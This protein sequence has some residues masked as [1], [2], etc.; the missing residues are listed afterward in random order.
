MLNKPGFAA[1]R[2]RAAL[3]VAMGVIV[4][5]SISS[6]TDAANMLHRRASK[7]NVKTVVLHTRSG[8]QSRSTTSRPVIPSQSKNNPQSSTI[9]TP[10]IDKEMH[11]SGD[12][13][14]SKYAAKC[15]NVPFPGS[16]IIAFN[17]HECWMGYGGSS[18]ST[19]LYLLGYPPDSGHRRQVMIVS[20]V[21]VNSRSGVVNLRNDA[22]QAFMVNFGRSCAVIGYRRSKTKTYYSPSK[23]R[24]VS[25]CS[26]RR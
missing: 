9:A 1:E 17:I 13:F 4:C 10:T 23:H 3:V 14:A 24:V 15:S 18:K 25:S 20:S 16:I 22:G 8:S 2:R 7:N 6:C 26:W 19:E 5:M 21:Y 12:G 11:V